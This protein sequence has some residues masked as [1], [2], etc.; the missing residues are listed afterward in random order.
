MIII[1]KQLHDILDKVMYTIKDYAEDSYN[2]GHSMNYDDF[3]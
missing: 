2:A 1:E 3:K